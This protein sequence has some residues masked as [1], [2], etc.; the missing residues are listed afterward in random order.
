MIAVKDAVASATEFA[1]TLLDS[2]RASQLRLEEVE[3]STTLTGSD[4]WLITLSMPGINSFG[5]PG[6]GRDFKTFT[7]DGQTG[8]VLSMKIRQFAGAG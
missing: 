3:E 4:R 2:E 8:K 6:Q 1:K 7:V 5:F